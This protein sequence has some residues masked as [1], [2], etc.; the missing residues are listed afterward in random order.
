[1]KAACGKLGDLATD[2]HFTRARR[3]LVFADGVPIPVPELSVRAVT[4]APN[5]A[6]REQRTRMRGARGK[7]DDVA[8]DVHVTRTRRRLVVADGVAVPVPEL[9][10][11]RISPAPNPTGREQRTSVFPARDELDDCPAD[12]HVTCTRGQF[13]VADVVDDVVRVA[14]PEPSFAA[15][16]PAANSTGREQ[17]ASVVR[18]RGKLDHGPADVH[19]ACTRRRLVVADCIRV[20]VPELTDT[21][22]SPA[23]N[24]A[25]REQRARVFP[26]C[27]KLD[28]GATHIHVTCA[29]R[30]LVL[31]DATRM[32]VTELS[33]VVMSPAA[34]LAA[35]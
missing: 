15:I 3:Q 1:V 11:I 27:G 31:A 14:V 2:V 28:D 32:S 34:D 26:A 4:P 7:L 6:A 29:R 17:R 13:V 9:S 23:A 8:T 5:L 33:P 22:G 16:S 18:A 24:P 30:Q 35:R 19:V 12:V 20:T 10:A 21:V 25:A